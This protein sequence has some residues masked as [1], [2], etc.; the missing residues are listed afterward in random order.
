MVLIFLY[1]LQIKIFQ[2]VQKH[3][4][5]SVSRRVDIFN[6]KISKS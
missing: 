4:F 3:T 6:E 1:I 2:I 5:I